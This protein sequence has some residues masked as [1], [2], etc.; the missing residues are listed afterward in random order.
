[1]LACDQKARFD[2]FVPK[3]EAAFAERYIALFQSR[4][5]DAIEAGI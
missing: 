4:D 1:V 3:E 5:F 2:K